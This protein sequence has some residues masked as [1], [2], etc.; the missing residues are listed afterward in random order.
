MPKSAAT[1]HL[2]RVCPIAGRKSPAQRGRAGLSSRLLSLLD[3]MRILLLT[4]N[5]VPETNSPARRAYEHAFEWVAKGAQI[6]VITSIPNFPTGRPLPPYRN[7]LWQV[8]LCDGI[9]VV[10]VWTFLSAN[11]G[12][13]WR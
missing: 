4:D 1:A 2:L 5:F 12:I 9:R 3:R 6:T 7:R 11:R 8:E 10:R 13:V